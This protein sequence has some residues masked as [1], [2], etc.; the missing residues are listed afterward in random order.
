MLGAY[1]EQIKETHKC[2]ADLLIKG[3]PPSVFG[4]HIVDLGLWYS[5]YV[6]RTIK[7]PKK[8]KESISKQRGIL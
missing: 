6:F 1:E 3:L 5:L 4:E 7:R 8:I 2:F